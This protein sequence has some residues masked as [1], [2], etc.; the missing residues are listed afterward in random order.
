MAKH[1]GKDDVGIEMTD[2]NLGAIPL[3]E[4]ILM[5]AGCNKDDAS[6]TVRKFNEQLIAVGWL[7]TKMRKAI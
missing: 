5:V 1:V 6:A 4:A 3:L 2:I 7:V